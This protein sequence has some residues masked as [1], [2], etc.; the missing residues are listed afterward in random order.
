MHT[1]IHIRTCA[2]THARTHSRT[3]AHT[4]SIH[5]HNTLLSLHFNAHTFLCWHCCILQA[6]PIAQRFMR[7]SQCDNAVLSVVKR[8]NKNKKYVGFRLFMKINYTIFLF[9][10]FLFISSF[11]FFFLFL[12]KILVVFVRSEKSNHQTCVRIWEKQEC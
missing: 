11:L 4:I 6:L 5:V 12:I 10:I 2:R 3:Y 7:F 9:M 1:H 8:M